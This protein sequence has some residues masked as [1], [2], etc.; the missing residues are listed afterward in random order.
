MP[1][2]PRPL[3]LNVAL[4]VRRELEEIVGQRVV[5]HA[6]AQRARILLLAADGLSAPEIARRVGCTDRTVRTWRARFRAAP[7]VASLRDRHRTGRP[8]KVSVAT[9][10][11]LVQLACERP[12]PAVMAFRDV[13]TS[14][15]S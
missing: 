1:R 3:P 2:G 6:Y 5:S 11:R 14:L 13:W 4:Q 9:R 12:D 10:C 15:L 8:A 7:R